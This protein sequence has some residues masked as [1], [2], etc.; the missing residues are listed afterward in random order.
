LKSLIYDKPHYPYLQRH[1][2]ATEI[3]P[4]VPQSV[5]NQLMGHSKRSN[6]QEVYVN[7]LGTEGNRELLIARA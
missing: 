6:L 5:F 1:G 7:D 2:F 4:K 3:A